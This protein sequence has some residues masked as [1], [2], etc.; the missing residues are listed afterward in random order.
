MDENGIIFVAGILL[1]I[2]VVLGYLALT[3]G[4]TG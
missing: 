3:G 2:G 4:L 1:F